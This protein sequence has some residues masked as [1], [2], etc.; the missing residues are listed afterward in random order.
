MAIG[1]PDTTTVLWDW[2]KI[3]FGGL[4][5]WFLR[6]W[7]E[8]RDK[9]ADRGRGLV[10][11]A[12]PELVPTGN[13]GD[14]YT[15]AINVE[16]RGKGTARTLRIGFTGVQEI[17]TRD[18]V[19]AGQERL[20]ARLNVQG[21]PFFTEAHNGHG[22]ITLVYADRFG[23]E[24]SLIIP[25]ARQKRADGGFNM[26]FDWTNYSTIEPTLTK[27]RLREIGRI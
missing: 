22:E 1:V 21:S 17:A 7:I 13:F 18:D 14:Q 19:P 4:I 15:V 16:N 10:D 6:R 11:D 20:T 27:K 24:Y 2:L 26:V 8:R 5:G 9:A 12:R 23:N 25:V 3:S